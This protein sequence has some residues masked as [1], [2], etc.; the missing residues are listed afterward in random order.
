MSRIPHTIVAT[1]F[2]LAVAIAAPA[3][4]PT[5]ALA[6]TP[7]VTPVVVGAEP[8]AQAHWCE[9]L[10]VGTVPATLTIEV[11]NPGTGVVIDSVVQTVLPGQAGRLVV[12]ASMISFSTESYCR[13][14]GIS[15]TKVRVTH[16]VLANT[17]ICES[18]VTA[19]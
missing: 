7:I 4:L 19:P 3:A 2:T 6:A 17:G 10:N 9:V 5:H 18:T 12:F 1:V 15:K 14:S 13:V 8:G 11:V 16:C